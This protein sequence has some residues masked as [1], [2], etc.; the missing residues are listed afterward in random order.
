[1]E[2]NQVSALDAESMK[3][4]S[5]NWSLPTQPVED[6]APEKK[7]LMNPPA[8]RGLRGASSPVVG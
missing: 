5:L 1:M 3:V 8:S 7:Y 2:L 4:A 6:L